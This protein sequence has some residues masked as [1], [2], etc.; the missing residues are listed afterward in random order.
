MAIH[1]LKYYKICSHGLNLIFII[2][3]MRSVISSKS[4]FLIIFKNGISNSKKWPF[5]KNQP[6]GDPPGQVF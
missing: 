4:D 1:E 5:F 2:F 6:A 3:S